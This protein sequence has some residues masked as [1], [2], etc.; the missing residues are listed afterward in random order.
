MA[1]TAGNTLIRICW[2]GTAAFGAVTAAAVLVDG[3]VRTAAAALDIVL[4]AVGCVVF[5]WAFGLAV[6][7]SR[8]ESIGIGGLYFLAGCAPDGVRRGFLACLAVQVI[9]GVASASL[10]PFTALAFGV[11]VP[12]FGL[13]LGGLWAARHGEF[14]NRPEATRHR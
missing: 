1:N 8:Y 7:R 2:A 10:R 4:F 6:G 11:L 14:A 12:V 13:G 3:P 9:V 5:L